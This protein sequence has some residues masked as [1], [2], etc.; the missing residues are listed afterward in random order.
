MF[1]KLQVPG[2]Y[3][4]KSTATLQKTKGPPKYRLGKALLLGEPA[5]TRTQDTRIKSPKQRL[6]PPSLSVR[7]WLHNGVFASGRFPQHPPMCAIFREIG[8]PLAHLAR[9]F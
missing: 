5:G 6:P 2:F 8:T 4:L 3:G 7:K 9:R 1:R